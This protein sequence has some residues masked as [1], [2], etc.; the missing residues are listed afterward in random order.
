MELKHCII[1]GVSTGIG[2]AT[3]LELLSRGHK[4]IGWGLNEPDYGHFNFEFIRADVRSLKDVEDAWAKSQTHLPR[5]SADVLMN[6]A[7][8]GYF[9]NIEDYT[10][11]QFKEIFEVN[12]FGLWH[13]CRVVIPAMK[14]AG[15]GHIVN[16][17][18][19]AG[20]DGMAQVSIYCGAKHAVRGISESLFK[21]LREFGIKVTTVYPGSVQTP[22]FKN[23]PGIQS[24]DMMMQPAEVAVQIANAIDTSPNFNLN[25]IEF[26]PLKV[27]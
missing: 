13:A 18:S 19:T 11:E 9:G 1:T 6:N 15:S 2:K 3:A 24:H 14:R 5:G 8:L 17:S 4:V 20:L 12:V 16:I 22:F 21:E 23:S 27:K 10:E 26:R 7:G 25:S